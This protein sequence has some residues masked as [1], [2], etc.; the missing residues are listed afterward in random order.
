MKIFEGGLLNQT[1]TQ[2]C[3]S[4]AFLLRYPHMCQEWRPKRQ[5]D[6][7]SWNNWNTKPVWQMGDQKISLID[8]SWCQC[9]NRNPALLFEVWMQ[10][11]RWDMR[12]RE[13]SNGFK[14]AL[15]RSCGSHHL[16]RVGCENYRIIITLWSSDANKSPLCKV[17]YLLSL[18]VKLKMH[19]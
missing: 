4:P 6:L 9:S 17:R 12:V 13:L 7:L 10:T 1:V 11:H 3:F 18:Y 14:W 2:A 16:Q 8:C 19:S 15:L 5:M